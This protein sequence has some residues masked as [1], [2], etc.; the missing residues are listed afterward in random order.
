M[1]LEVSE[2]PSTCC[3]FRCFPRQGSR[4]DCVGFGATLLDND[5]PSEGWILLHVQRQFVPDLLQHMV[6]DKLA[7]IYKCSVSWRLHG[8]LHKHLWS[9]LPRSKLLYHN[10]ILLTILGCKHPEPS[11][12]YQQRRYQC[13]R[14]F[15]T[16]P[17]LWTSSSGTF[18]HTQCHECSGLDLLFIL[19]K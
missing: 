8:L 9:F 13:H 1:F 5:L 12:C 14:S 18:N 7:R 15:A 19:W 2:E 11:I 4:H 6:P 17:R 16:Q 3:Y 10:R